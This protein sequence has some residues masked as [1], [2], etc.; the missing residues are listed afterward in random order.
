MYYYYTLQDYTEI[1][2]TCPSVKILSLHD[3]LELYYT[4]D[5]TVHELYQSILAVQTERHY[6]QERPSTGYTEHFQEKRLYEELEKVS[7]TFTCYSLHSLQCTLIA[8]KLRVSKH[9]PKT[10]A[11][12]TPLHSTLYTDVISEPITAQG[13]L[14]YGEDR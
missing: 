13:I 6:K 12:V 8:G 4:P 2:S 5:N 9:H 14:I 10:E 3:Y 11:F 1:L 7:E